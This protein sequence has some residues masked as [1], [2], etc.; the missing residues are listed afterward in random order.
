M[1]TKTRPK[2]TSEPAFDPVTQYA[3][4]VSEGAIVAGPDVRAACRRHLHDLRH[5][6]ARG[7]RWD[8]EAAMRIINFYPDV[9]RLNGGE[10]EGVPFGLLPWEAF[11]VGSLFGW[12]RADDSR[13]FREAYVESAKG[14]G[15][16]P[17]AAGVGLYML[18]ADGEERAEVYAAATKKEQAQILFRDAVAMVDLSPALT[19]RIT[20]SGRAERT[21]NLAYLHKASFFR[22]IASDSTGQSGPRP[23][24]A[25]IDEIHEHKDR[26]VIDMMQAGKKGRR[27]PLIFMIT[28]SGFD[29]TSLCYEKHEYGQKVAAQQL[30]DDAFFAFICSL[31]E[32]EDPFEDEACWVKAN[33]SLGQTIQ[34]SYLDEQVRQA[35]GMPSLE[36]TVRRLNFCQ[37]VDAADPWI[38]LDLWTPCEVGAPTL[39]QQLAEQEAGA[40]LWTKVVEQAMTERDALLDRMKGRDVLGGLDLSGT[41]DLTA[42]AAACVQDDGS[43]DALVEFWTPDATID[44]RSRRDHVPY[45]VWLKAGFLHAS[46]GRAIDYADVVKRLAELDAFLTIAG[47]AFDPYRI[48]YF[49]QDLDDAALALKLVPHGQGFH[50]AA[51]SG[52]WMPRSIE[53]MEQLV[54]DRKLRVAFNPCLRWNVTSAV[55][56]TDP[57]N[58]RIFNKRKATGRIDGLVALTMAVAL[59]LAGE[60]E[61]QPEYQMFFL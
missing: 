5:G 25:L 46:K 51:G 19:A 49:E 43:V 21:F 58:N 34:R 20:K 4:D 60:T 44:E 48:K 16:S 22:T 29:R 53:L 56:D 35:R 30:E 8:L 32:G 41:R 45:P 1:T 28:N 10:F 61:R 17:L 14:S 9:L 24:C 27:Q 57:K 36:S 33:P 23:H 6:K 39:A 50:R 52:L 2:R 59:A 26:T 11:V 18:V 13:R 54:F 38:S 3:R 31:D 40:A 12:K 47:I 7:L 42:L 15:K 37:W 55:T